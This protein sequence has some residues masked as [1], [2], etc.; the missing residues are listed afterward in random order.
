MTAN[1]VAGNQDLLNLINE[2]SGL[3]VRVKKDGQF[4]KKVYCSKIYGRVFR[5]ITGRCSWSLIGRFD[6][7]LPSEY[8]I[9]RTNSHLIE[10]YN[11]DKYESFF[12]DFKI[13]HSLAFPCEICCNRPGVF[14]LDG[15]RLAKINM[16]FFGCTEMIQCCRQCNRDYDELGY[17]FIP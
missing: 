11:L 1:E 3:V 17:Y 12:S 9:Q 4:F 10:Y 15:R 7:Y 13:Q 6:D 14:E 8:V 2:F 5:E 16:F